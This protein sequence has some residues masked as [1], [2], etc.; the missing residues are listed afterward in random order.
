M[1][2]FSL[3]G[4]SNVSVWGTV[5]EGKIKGKSKNFK[6]AQ[7]SIFLIETN[8]RIILKRISSNKKGKYDTELDFDNYY[9][10]VFSSPGFVSKFVTIDF[11]DIPVED[12]VGGFK[13]HIDISLFKQIEGIDYSLLNAPIGK[14]KYYAKTGV[15]V[16]DMAYTRDMM[17][18]V[19]NIK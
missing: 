14:A 17:R 2:S 5:S 19:R 4:Q 8:N 3:M 12:R 13:M 6:E 18:K 11:R 7:I 15:I 10:I 1:V 16:W 9:K